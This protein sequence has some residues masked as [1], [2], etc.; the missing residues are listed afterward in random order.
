MIHRGCLGSWFWMYWC[1][2]IMW[3]PGLSELLFCDRKDFL[4]ILTRGRC[5]TTNIYRSWFVFL[6]GRFSF[7]K[8]IIWWKSTHLVEDNYVTN[9]QNPRSACVYF[10]QFK[11]ECRRSNL[12]FSCWQNG[13]EAVQHRRHC[14]CSRI[15][16]F[17]YWKEVMWSVS[18]LL[19]LTQL[20]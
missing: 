19:E 18:Q 3:T 4:P 13:I 16:P 8:R 9:S 7:Q 10:F 6:N 14:S 15:S 5:F 20:V 2:E 17:L 11:N 1:K 12:C